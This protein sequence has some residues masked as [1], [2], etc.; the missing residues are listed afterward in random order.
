MLCLTLFIGKTN[1]QTT[2]YY[3]DFD[4]SYALP[5]GWS[6]VASSNATG[7]LWSIDST[8]SSYA[9]NG[10]DGYTGASGLN[11]VVVQNVWNTG[12]A[13]NTQLYTLYTCNIST[14]NFDNVNVIWAARNTKHFEDDGSA[15]SFWMSTNN[16]ASWDSI[17]YFENSPDSYWFEDNNASP[18]S[19][20]SASH[21]DNLMFKW[22]AYVNVTASGTYRI[23]DFTVTGTSSPSGIQETTNKPSALVYVVNN[24]TINVVAKDVVDQKLTVELF[25]MLGQ[26][27]RKA[28]MTSSALGINVSDLASGVYLVKVS[29][30]ATSEVTKVALSR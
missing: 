12:T 2:I 23:D 1:A 22:I 28:P 6:S 25:D 20:P 7:N 21:Q 10:T 18:I 27:I 16:G 30:G 14:Q 29:N 9:P 17:V 8:N 11:N 15:I 5:T 24:S 13:P 26:S 3:Q 4:S 19:I